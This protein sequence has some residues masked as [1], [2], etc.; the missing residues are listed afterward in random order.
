M[1]TTLRVLVSL[2][3]GLIFSYA[4]RAQ[5]LAN[6][7]NTVYQDETHCLGGPEIRGEKD[8]PI[9]C[10]CRDA[11][12][13]VRY[14]YQTYL[15]PGKDD[16]LTGTCLTLM[17]NATQM[18]GAYDAVSKA[19]EKDWRWNGPE[20]VR[21]YPSEREIEQIKPDKSGFRDVLYE[22]HL[23][24]R[25]PQGR[26]TNV[27]TF[28]VSERLPLDFKKLGCPPSAICPK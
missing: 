23:T 9:S 1:R 24:Y 20:V 26:V 10:Y 14:V 16:N 15:L 12:T 13:D 3:I 2:S 18:C 4:G 11:L 27:E 21:K 22:V 5:N 17:S 19:R 25:D 8:K 7:L 6:S 28:K